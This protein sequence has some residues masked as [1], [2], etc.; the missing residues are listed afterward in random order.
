MSVRSLLARTLRLA[1]PLYLSSLVLG[2]LP[3]ALTML[4]AYVLVADRPWRGDLLGPGWLN[5]ASEVAMT[6]FYTRNA[7]GLTQIAIAVGVL[8]PL[9]LFGQM[10]AYSYLTG[11]IVA[12]LRDIFPG[13]SAVPDLPFRAACRTWFWPSF[14]LSMLG[15]VLVLAVTIGGAVVAN[16]ARSTI[17]P[18]LG[19]IL[20]QAMV[21]VVAGWLELA[22]AWM[23]TASE[24]SVG[25]ALERAARFAIRPLVLVLWLALSIPTLAVTLVALFPPSISDPYSGLGLVEALAFGQV[26]AFLGAWTKVVRLAV[27]VRLTYQPS[28]RAS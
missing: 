10:V 26:V 5:V 25:R 20:P 3:V 6:A 13:A 23:V 24:R 14:R 4:G 28:V 22:R 19:A 11:G 17:G 21:A 2:L 15:G 9:M 27:A 18:D 12:S 8:L 1:V 7:A 16:L